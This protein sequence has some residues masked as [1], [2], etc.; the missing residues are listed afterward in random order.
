MRPG[1]AAPAA[2]VARLTPLEAVETP[3]ST[4]FAVVSFIFR[5]AFI[6][7]CRH[8][9]LLLLLLP[10]QPHLTVGRFPD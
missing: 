7:D 10:L 9:L 2:S 5:S 8:L 3:A 6:L 4:A 1:A